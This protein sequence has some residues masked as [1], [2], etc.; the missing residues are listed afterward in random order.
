MTVAPSQELS[1]ATRTCLRAGN[2]PSRLIQLRRQPSPSG[3]RRRTFHVSKACYQPQ[4]D[5]GLTGQQARRPAHLADLLRALTS[6]L[7]PL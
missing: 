4:Q 1:G 2:S 3:A 6:V 7:S 5:G